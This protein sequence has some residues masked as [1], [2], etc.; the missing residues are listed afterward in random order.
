MKMRLCLTLVLATACAAAAHA[1]FVASLFSGAALTEDNDLR[2]KQSDGTDLTFHN[3]SY[4]G[5]DFESPIYYG[6]R[7]TYFLPEMSH[8]GFGLEFFH[9][10]LYLNADDTVHVTGAR[11]GGPIDDRERVGDTIEAFN[12]SHGLNFLTADAV[13][14]WVLG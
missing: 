12:L 9:A 3:V 6:A 8:W 11:G 4:E 5:K 13:Y 14:R 7:L 10:K 1:E 2:L